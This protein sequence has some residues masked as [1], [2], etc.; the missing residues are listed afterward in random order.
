M[1]QNYKAQKGFTLIEL[2]IVV[3][4]I[5]IL[6]AIAIPAYNQYRVTAA[7][8]AC[9]S[10]VRSFASIY[11]ASFYDNADLPTY[12]GS[13]SDDRAC[14]TDDDGGGVAVTGPTD[15]VITFTGTPLDPGNEDQVYEVRIE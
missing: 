1:K 12:E 11:M 3:A 10:D 9:N 4:I 5:G 13:T 14:D 6:A 8:G 15:G 7:E 2:L